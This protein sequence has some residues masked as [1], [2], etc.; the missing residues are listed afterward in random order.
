[1][2]VSEETAR[3]EAASSIISKLL[4]LL[5]KINLKKSVPFCV[6]LGIYSKRAFFCLHIDKKFLLRK[7]R[8]NKYAARYY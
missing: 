1:M 6:N 3:S 2:F 5:K 8:G 4:K 7:Q